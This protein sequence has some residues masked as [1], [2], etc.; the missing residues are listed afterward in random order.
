MRAHQ[1]PE[2]CI[3]RLVGR[4]LSG[5]EG[6]QSFLEEVRVPHTRLKADYGFEN[7][8]IEAKSPCGRAKGREQVK[9]T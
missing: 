8:V 9:S 4:A 7:I 3:K 5:I 6:V 1:G 2:V